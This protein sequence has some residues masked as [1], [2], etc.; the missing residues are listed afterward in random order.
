MLALNYWVMLPEF[1]VEEGD[2]PLVYPQAL[3]FGCVI[4]AVLM[5]FIFHSRYGFIYR[6]NI[7][8]LWQKSEFQ[9][10]LQHLIV[11]ESGLTRYLGD[12]EWQQYAEF[13]EK[14]SVFLLYYISE[15]RENYNVIPKHAFQSEIEVALFR[16]FLQRKG[17]TEHIQVFL[18]CSGT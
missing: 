14:D 7:N 3:F 18:K 8:C 5:T 6:W 11:S 1:A 12:Q 10:N 4:T 9:E 16:D 17:K 13:I 2:T 15:S